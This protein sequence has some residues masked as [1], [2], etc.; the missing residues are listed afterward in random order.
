MFY[1]LDLEKY[2]QNDL[3]NDPFSYKKLK[4]TN[5]SFSEILE[6]KLIVGIKFGLEMISDDRYGGIF[7]E[8]LKSV[9]KGS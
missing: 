7:S 6:P 9:F 5:L 4:I 8:R 1:N 3:K 2:P